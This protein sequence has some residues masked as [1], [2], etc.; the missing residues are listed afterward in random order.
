MISN[1]ELEKVFEKFNS[2]LI[3]YSLQLGLRNLPY[4]NSSIQKMEDQEDREEDNEY[5][6]NLLNS[7]M[8]SD[9]RLLS[10]LGRVT[11]PEMIIEAISTL[12]DIINEDIIDPDAPTLNDLLKDN[13]NHRLVYT[14]NNSQEIIAAI[15]NYKKPRMNRKNYVNIDNIVYVCEHLKKMAQGLTVESKNWQIA[16]WD[17]EIWEILSV[18]PFSKIY[19]AF[20][21]G[22]DVAIK[23]MSYQINRVRVRKE[24]YKDVKMWYNLKHPNVLSLY[25][26]YQLGDYPFVVIPLM[27]NGNLISY[28]EGKEKLS[29]LNLIEILIGISSGMEYLHS[30]NVVHGDLMARN[31]LLDENLQPHI[32]DFGF[33][34]C[35]AVVDHHS[36]LKRL[37][38]LRWTANEVHVSFVYTK[39][40]DVYSFAMLCY[41]LF[42]WGN[43]PFQNL[44]ERFLSEAV[45]SGKRPDYP[46]DCPM[47]IWKLMERM[48]D[49][50]P[51]ARPNFTDIT[52]YLCSFRAQLKQQV[53]SDEE[54]FASDDTKDNIY[55]VYMDDERGSTILPDVLTNENG[56]S[57]NSPYL[58]QNSTFATTSSP[59]VYNPGAF[60]PIS[61]HQRSPGR[62]PHSPN[63]FVGIEDGSG[64]GSGSIDLNSTVSPTTSHSAKY[65][66]L[67]QEVSMPLPSSKSIPIPYIKN[68]HGRS[69]LF[70]NGN[71]RG[72]NQNSQNNNQPHSLSGSFNYNHS[73]YSHSPTGHPK[74][75]TAEMLPERLSSK[76]NNPLMGKQINVVQSGYRQRSTSTSTTGPKLS[77]SPNILSPTTGKHASIIRMP[78]NGNTPTIKRGNPSVHHYIPSE[79]DN[80]IYHNQNGY[81]FA[82]KDINENMPPTSLYITRAEREVIDQEILNELS[83]SDD[84]DLSDHFIDDYFEDEYIEETITQPN[85]NEMDENYNYRIQKMFK[86]DVEFNSLLENE[87]DEHFQYLYQIDDNMLQEAYSNYG[88][89]EN[90]Q[91]AVPGYQKRRSTQNQGVLSIDT[92]RRSRSR[93][94]SHVSAGPGTHSRSRSRSRS[95]SRTRSKSSNAY[96]NGR[97]VLEMDT[98]DGPGMPTPSTGP[99]K[100]SIGRTLSSEINAASI[101][102]AN[103]QNKHQSQNQSYKTPPSS[104]PHSPYNERVKENDGA[105]DRGKAN[106]NINHFIK[107]VGN[108]K[109]GDDSE[110]DKNTVSLESDTYYAPPISESTDSVYKCEI[111][112][113]ITF[114]LMDLDDI[115]EYY[116]KSEFCLSN[117]T[118]PNINKDDTEDLTFTSAFIDQVCSEIPLEPPVKKDFIREMLLDIY[119]REFKERFG[120]FKFEETIRKNRIEFNTYGFSDWSYK[121]SAYKVLIDIIKYTHIHHIYIR[122]CRFGDPAI[123]ALAKALI[124]NNEFTVIDITFCSKR[125]C[126]QQDNNILDIIKYDASNL[127]PSWILNNNVTSKSGQL[128]ANLI[129]QSEN[130]K[131]IHLRNAAFGNDCAIMMANALTKN[132]TIED[133]ELCNCL[134][135]ES[136]AIAFAD[137]LQNNEVLLR[138]ILQQNDI[139][140]KGAIAISSALRKNMTLKY[141]LLQRCGISSKA[142]SSFTPTF[143]NN[144]GLEL[145]KY[146]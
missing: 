108:M 103:Y 123:V 13:E 35:R 62:S 136:A 146:V 90:A 127:D 26:A 144:T 87:N 122:N 132:N 11:E 104:R 141:L 21:L 113:D 99:R 28:I 121:R 8:R 5:F 19:K 92:T 64:S 73:N 32:C 124:R 139:G 30:K 116:P 61:Y 107:I 120:E 44:S 59:H 42:T 95:K 45:I 10:F 118:F 98:L 33:S 22:L 3:Y 93:S 9:A 40:S 4:L 39:K 112:K 34:K 56:S 129:H 65:S 27:K 101:A 47:A 31:I 57:N 105:D 115:S 37:D 131:A 29:L 137:M 66:P 14:Q 133:F 83:L 79:E 54:Y 52:N 85:F 106:A 86:E 15:R 134:V 88:N 49:G 117:L 17:I 38:S 102:V 46:E 114:S 71:N 100:I 50:N 75:L 53:L 110:Q 24:F 18:G 68:G 60:S 72:Q 70:N 74:Q 25:G 43:V 48:W 78:N 41:E 7:A 125:S 140:D 23:E 84:E 135:G 12:E 82:F 109:L 55:A 63:L 96:P 67:H 142:M 58:N 143:L 130:L 81:D 145:V 126:P 138:L 94:R 119:M 111:K 16:S 1:Y 97:H 91:Y 20:W 51:E 89:F 128:F 76:H 77:S 6:N 36:K 69:V 2:Q 80:G